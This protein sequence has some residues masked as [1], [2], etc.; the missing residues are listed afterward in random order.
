MTG[1]SRPKVNGAD[2]RPEQQ[3]LMQQANLIGPRLAQNARKAS[4][5]WDVGF[6]PRAPLIGSSGHIFSIGHGCRVHCHLVLSPLS[7][8]FPEVQLKG[9]SQL[10]W[11]SGKRGSGV[12]PYGHV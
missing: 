12:K 9:L 4:K 3:A 1:A 7:L 5:D 2:L 11:L 10:D 8:T 6:R